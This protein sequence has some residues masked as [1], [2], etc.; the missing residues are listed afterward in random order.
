MS[1]EDARLEAIDRWWSGGF[2]GAFLVEDPLE[3]RMRRAFRRV[4]LATDADDFAFFLDAN[5]TL[6]CEPRG[7]GRVGRPG[8]GDFPW[9]SLQR[10][11]RTTP[12]GGIVHPHPTT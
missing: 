11:L 10:A 1:A 8:Q 7:A 4:L 3:E 6:L 5:P 2:P 12:L 9:S